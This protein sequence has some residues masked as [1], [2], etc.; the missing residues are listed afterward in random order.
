MRTVAH[1][2]GL[3]SDA[4]PRRYLWTDA[5]AVCNFLELYRR[6][7]SDVYL[8]LALRLVDQVHHTLGR[9]RE[10]DS[11]TGWISGLGEQ[12]GARHPTAGGLRIGKKLHERQPGETYDARQEWDRDGQYF[13][14]L[15]KWMHALNRVSGIADDPTYRRWAVELAQVAHDR[16]TYTPASG[17]KRRMYWKM[18]IDLSRPLVPSM[19]QHDPLDGY[20]TYL[21]LDAALERDP[22]AG[23]DSLQ[24]EIEDMA[25]I[26]E[27]M[28]WA[29]DDPL[30]LG[31]L[32]V[33]VH[34]ALHLQSTCPPEHPHPFA[35][36]P[37]T[38]LEDAARSLAAY[39]RRH[40]QAPPASR[41]LAFRELGLSIGLAAVEQ[42][43]TADQPSTVTEK[44]P[45]A[46][47]QQLLQYMPLRGD[48]ETFWLQPEHRASPTWK[49]H[50]DINM[51]MLATSLTPGAYLQT[52]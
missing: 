43:T 26:C 2:T 27:G 12:E 49:A 45:E 20:L 15:T 16:F 38:L 46:A 52:C 1:Q 37:N 7:E 41:R 25:A 3:T 22:D 30:G 33:D 35:A 42:M 28:R 39:T 24:A 34:R 9:H 14:Y 19:G 51:V 13:H 48:I 8:D 21:A 31:G 36:L 10:E 50:A 23:Q 40:I 29:T 11:R 47:R 5:F 44:T 4:P 32:L 6:T 18:S 17:D